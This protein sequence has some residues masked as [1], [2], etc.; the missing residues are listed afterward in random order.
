MHNLWRDENDQLRCD[1]R[2]RQSREQGVANAGDSNLP[3]ITVPIVLESHQQLARRVPADCEL[4]HDVRRSYCIQ[5]SLNFRELE[6]EWSQA[7]NMVRIQELWREHLADIKSI[8]SPEFWQIFLTVHTYSGVAIDASLSSVKN[9]FVPKGTNAW[10][11]FPATRRVLL[12][13][14]RRRAPFWNRVWHM[15]RID[16]Q[17]FKLASGTKYVDFEFI[18]PLWAWIMAASKQNPCDLHW[19]PFTQH[20]ANPRYGAGVQYGKTFRTACRSCPAG[21]YSTRHL[22]TLS[23]KSVLE[24]FLTLSPRGYNSVLDLYQL[25]H[26]VFVTLSHVTLTLSESTNQLCHVV[27]RVSS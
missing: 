10:R 27:F 21:L 18:D 14:I 22:S 24:I 9:V 19:K 8:A 17:A 6:T 25:C 23:H 12:D 1:W 15:H 13:K 2:L 5:L 16:V 3:L 20:A 4:A 7:R 11:Q 26:I